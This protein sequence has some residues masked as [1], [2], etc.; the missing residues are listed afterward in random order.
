[1]RKPECSASLGTL[2]ESFFDKRMVLQQN[3]SQ[4][5]ID[6][7]RIT[8][9]LLLRFLIEKYDCSISKISVEVITAET[10]LE[11]LDFL[12]GA[13]HCSVRTRNQRRAAIRAFAR[14]VIL[15]EPRLMEQFTRVLAI[16]AKRA[17]KKVLGYLT[18][19]EMNA[20]LS[21]FDRT[22]LHGRRGYAM[23]LFMYNSGTR[24]SEVVSVRCQDIRHS[25][26][27][28]RGKGNKDRIVPLWPDTV[29]VLW[30]LGQE[31]NLSLC[32]TE[33]LFR[34]AKG[35]P[36]TRSGIAYILNG[37]VENASLSCETLAGRR[38]SPHILRHTNAMHL[39]QSGVDI[40]LI[41]V[42]L[43]HVS[44]DT[45]HGYIEADIEMKRKALEK[46][47]VTAGSPSYKW[48]ASDEVKAFLD[49]LGIK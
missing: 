36:I 25:Q 35:R 37:A 44:L 42:W 15:T 27:L 1:M 45:T 34:N 8:W 46:G 7:Y 3:A 9:T 32:S 2:L 24:V 17:S 30:S 20:V 11:F 43:G 4:N 41:R 13:R 28:I 14:H 29:K 22:T 38:V 5:T 21:S 19:L 23:L 33:Q 40:N 12:E 6:S 31:E 18:K 48:K 39:L 47:G 10:V 26:A 16:P 49:T